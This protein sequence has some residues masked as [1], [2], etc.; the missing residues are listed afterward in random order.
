MKHLWMIIAIICTVTAIHQTWKSG[1]NESY[2][3]F[4]FAGISLL[5]YLLRNYLSKKKQKSE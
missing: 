5:M 2:R 3:F 4:I 1:I